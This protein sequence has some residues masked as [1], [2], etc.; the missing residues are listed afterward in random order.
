MINSRTADNQIRGKFHSLELMKNGNTNPIKYGNEKLPIF[1]LETY[2]FLVTNTQVLIKDL[3]DGN[4]YDVL[5]SNSELSVTIDSEDIK[6]KKG[7]PAVVGDSFFIKQSPAPFCYV[8]DTGAINSSVSSDSLWSESVMG[9]TAEGKPDTYAQGFVRQGSSDHGGLFLRKDG[10]WGQPAVFSGSVSEHFLSLDDTPT[11]YNDNLDKYLRVSYSDGGCVVFDAIDTSKVP[12]DVSN[13]YYT[14]TRVENKITE[15]TSDRSLLNLLVQNKITANEFVC[16]S[17]R[18]LK[19]NISNL[20]SKESLKNIVLLN[21]KEYVFKGKSKKR[22]GLISQEVKE[23]FP[24]LITEVAESGF[25]QINYL[26]LIPHLVNCI[27][28]LNVKID[29]LKSQL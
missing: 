9:F 25:Q 5:H 15:K 18:R 29:E 28:E 24:A 12:E 21:P 14:E 11:E 20:N 13:L 3:S 1:F 16:D 22:Y 8:D 23:I 19:E 17:D 27:K 26:E 10:N 6:V 7:T 4:Y 2:N